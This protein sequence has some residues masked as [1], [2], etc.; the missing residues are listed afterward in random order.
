MGR[1]LFSA[2]LPPF[3]SWPPP[4]FFKVEGTFHQKNRGGL[5]CSH[6]VEP[7]PTRDSRIRREQSS[8][9][10]WLSLRPPPAAMLGHWHLQ[11][12]SVPT[13]RLRRLLG[14]V[15]D[16]GRRVLATVKWVH[17]GAAG[18]MAQ[19]ALVLTHSTYNASTH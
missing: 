8:S 19:L 16:G 1:A 15:G 2:S 9:G 4:I 12:T 13:A 5:L 14:I 18:A 11:S 7:L 17:A 3:R 10:G 6:R